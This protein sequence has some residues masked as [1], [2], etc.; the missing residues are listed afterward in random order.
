[1]FKSDP[2]DICRQALEIAKNSGRPFPL[3][4]LDG[5]MPEIDGFTL[6]KQIQNNSALAGV[7][8]MMLTSAEELAI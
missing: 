5:Q 6:A 1:V 8:L 2:R 3:V 4:L 7:I